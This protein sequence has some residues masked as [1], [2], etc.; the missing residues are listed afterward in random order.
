MVEVRLLHG[1]TLKMQDWAIC[2]L[3]HDAA[4]QYILRSL[5]A[6]GPVRVQYSTSGLVTKAGVEAWERG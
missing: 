2:S 3:E 1:T 6:R 5:H 4:M